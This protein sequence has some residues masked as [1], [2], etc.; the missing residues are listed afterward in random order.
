MTP[1]KLAISLCFLEAFNA[2]QNHQITEK[3]Y[4]SHL[5]AHFRGVR[6]LQDSNVDH[7][8]LKSDPFGDSI[9]QMA[10]RP[11]YESIQGEKKSSFC[12]LKSPF[13]PLVDTTPYEMLFNSCLTATL[14]QV[15]SDI[16]LVEQ[17]S[18][19]VPLQPLTTL[20][21]V[22]G[23]ATILRYCLARGAVFDAALNTAVELGGNNPAIA[24]LVSKEEC[25]KTANNERYSPSQLQRW[26]GDINW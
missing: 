21:A 10:L 15:R 18:L 9:R 5:V 12:L 26:F 3:E 14:D 8:L 16:K 4:L 2:K 20:A 24:G 6:H 25:G 17:A 1:P 13:S 23:N 11:N 7:V 22:N 19:P